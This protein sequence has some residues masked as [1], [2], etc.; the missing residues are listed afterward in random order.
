MANTLNIKQNNTC[1]FNAATGKQGFLTSALRLL[2]TWQDRAAMRHHM[3]DLDE[4]IL[5]DIGKSRVE[6]QREAAKTFWVS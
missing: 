6:I 3:Q 1:E 5:S 2:T 4:H